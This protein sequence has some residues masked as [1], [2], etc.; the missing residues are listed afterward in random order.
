MEYQAT[1]KYLKISP[2][3]V[4]LL[5]D[6]LRGMKADIAMG[7]LHAMHQHAAKP[8]TSVLGSALA[9]AKEKRASQDALRLKTIEVMEGPV[10]KRWHAASRGMAHPYKKRMTHIRVV[11]TEIENTSKAK[12]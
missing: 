9:N 7:K 12:S 11:L 10:M 1:A 2:R 3:K 8:L 6:A 5:A 4:R